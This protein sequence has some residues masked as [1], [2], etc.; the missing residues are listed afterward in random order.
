VTAALNKPMYET[1][2]LPDFR[3]INWASSIIFGW[4]NI[5]IYETG[6]KISPG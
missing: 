4:L 2:S 3:R 5:S 6:I 1:R